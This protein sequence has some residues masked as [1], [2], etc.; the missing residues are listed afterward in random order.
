MA[1]IKIMDDRLSNQI[2]AGEV[3]ERPA[4]IVKELVEN[5]IDAGSTVLEVQV[6]EGGLGKIK[7][8]DNGSGMDREDSRLCFERHATSKIKSERELFRIKTLGFRG[9][10]LPSIAAVS[11]VTMQTW[12]QHEPTGTKIH[13]EA[14]EVLEMEDAPLRK[15]TVIEIN[16]LF[17][18]TPARYKYLRTVH[19]E[20]SHITD[21]M[22]RLALAYPAISFTLKHHDR[23]LLKTNGNG[24]TLSVIAAIYG[25]TTAK[26]MISFSAEH[27]DFQVEGYLG[28]PELSRSNRYHISIFMNGRYIKSPIVTQAILRAYQTLLPIHRFPIAVLS[29]KMDASLL[30]VN[31]HPAKLHVKFSKENELISWLESEMKRVLQQE[32]LIPE[33]LQETKFKSRE[34]N[35]QS[36]FDFRLPV[37]EDQVEKPFKEN[38]HVKETE[39][40]FQLKKQ[41]PERKESTS[42]IQGPELK[43]PES[44]KQIPLLYPLAQLHGTYI[45][46]QNENGLYMIDQHAAQERIWYERFVHKLNEPERNQQELAIPIVLEFTSTEFASVTVYEPLLNK[47]GLFLEQFGHH[48]YIVRSHPQWFPHGEEEN[49]IREIIDYIS[50]QKKEIEWIQVRD[51][52]AIMMSCKKSIKANHYLSRLEMEA[53]LEDIRQTSNPYTCPH[54]RPITVLITK[55]D[56][57]KMFKRIMS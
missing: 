32:Q 15:G 21:Y 18:N 28:R 30:D 20:L 41:I 25:H 2:A 53:L 44:S 27:I 5:S 46:A 11:K 7:V 23:Q 37:Q 34:K 13:I 10:A 54:G 3:V 8:I 26:K 9:E 31:V 12:D 43:E 24:Q 47:M 49:L 50:E 17:Y 40:P 36:V 4:S 42:S 22:N 55:Y 45:L 29:V 56:I 1:H 6:E 39:A 48:S 51:E 19:T 33:P 52:V 57:E 35:D 16:E 14:G 38:I